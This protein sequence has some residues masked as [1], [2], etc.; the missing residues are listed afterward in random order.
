MLSFPLCQEVLC[1][2]LLYLTSASGTNSNWIA[3]EG[4]FDVITHKMYLA[5]SIA[6]LNHSFPCR[7]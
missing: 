2:F 6:G 1:T 3:T 5:Y 7:V 4:F